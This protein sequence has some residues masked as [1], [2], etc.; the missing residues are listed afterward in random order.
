MRK[1]RQQGRGKNQICSKF[2]KIKN[3][4]LNLISCVLQEIKIDIQFCF[5]KIKGS[6]GGFL[7]LLRAKRRDKLSDRVILKGYNGIK[8]S[9]FLYLT[10]KL[11]YRDPICKTIELF[12]EKGG[13]TF[14][15]VQ[16][17]VHMEQNKIFTLNE[18]NTHVFF[19][20]DSKENNWK[21]RL[22]SWKRNWQ[23][24][25]SFVL[26]AKKATKKI[27]WPKNNA[28]IF[29]FL[30]RVPCSDAFV[31]VFPR[32]PD[33]QRASFIAFLD[34]RNIF[35]FLLWSI[36]HCFSFSPHLRLIPWLNLCGD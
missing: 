32:L 30:H 36:G 16:N 20:F 31:I 10:T 34:S 12:K 23:R 9:H 13:W 33:C 22:K 21:I 17:Y 25:K 2:F 27:Q 26:E 14:A 4:L 1:V 6:K 18:N 5:A 35:P 11:L 29:V 7:H 24:F 15:E 3:C 28:M 8:K 19:S